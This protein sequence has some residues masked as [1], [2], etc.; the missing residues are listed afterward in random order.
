[1]RSDFSLKEEASSSERVVVVDTIWE[2]GETL[3]GIRDK[4]V[5]VQ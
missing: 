5:F 4:K 2:K 3:G 1:M